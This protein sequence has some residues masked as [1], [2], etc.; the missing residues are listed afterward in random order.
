LGSASPSIESYHHACSGRYRLLRLTKRPG[1]ATLPLV[2]LVDMRTERVRGDLPFISYPLKKEVQNRLKQDEQ[3]ILYL[4]RRGYSPQ[5]K[6]A[7]CGYVPQCPHC[8]VN[9]TY[10][11]AGRKLSCHYCGFVTTGYDRCSKC[12]STDIL[13]LGAG[14]QKVEET[15]PRL[16]EGATVV[17]FDSD[18]T[19]GRTKAYRILSEFA[20]KKYNLLLG[21][22][23][24]TK[25]LD[26]PGVTIVGV[27]AAD[28]SLDFPDFRS[29]EKTFAQ[30][31]QVAGRSGRAERPGE[32]LI[33]TYYPDSEVIN[34]AAAQDYQA[35]Y[36]REIRSR[37]QLLYSP[38]LRLVNCI[39]SSTDEKK[40]QS[41][42]LSFRDRLQEMIKA[43]NLRVYLLGPA[44]CPLYYL[45]GRYRRHLIVKTR[46]VV[47][48][49]RMLTDWENCQ[50]RFKLPSLI[51]VVIDVD[52]DDMM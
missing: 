1:G 43:A 2:R 39:L 37:E 23:M 49:V 25:G 18:S 26:L 16:F 46:Q 21:T 32:V 4:N 27:L 41:S 15:I 38:F 5:L 28:L 34:A 44:P 31:L 10:H 12:N 30:L 14:T 50:P 8:R 29:S 6:C 11:K 19:T 42:A 24:V 9:L 52:P 35:F 36:E 13:Y 51:K 47:K 22:Q 7:D 20:Q 45:R 40:L 33:Q 48:F 3:V 17:R